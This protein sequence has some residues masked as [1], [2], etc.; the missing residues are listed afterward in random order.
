MQ[1]LV[2]AVIKKPRLLKSARYRALLT[3]PDFAW[4]GRKSPADLFKPG[5]LA[6]V[7]IKDINGTV[8]HVQLEQNV[9]PQAAIVAHR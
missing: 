4:T 9:G 5:D 3:Q 2:T 1:G 8:A 7:S 6:E